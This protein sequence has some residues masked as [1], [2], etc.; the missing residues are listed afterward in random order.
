MWPAIMNLWNLWAPKSERGKLI[1]FVA[2][3][4][5]IGVIFGFS[6]GCLLIMFFFIF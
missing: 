6:L 2:A 1:S 3:G 4:M 5:E